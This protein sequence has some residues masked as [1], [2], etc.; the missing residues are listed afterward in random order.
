MKQN[1]SKKTIDSLKNNKKLRMFFLFLIMSF[2][3]WMLIKLSEEYIADVKIEV[4]YIDQPN[5]KLL[6]SEPQN[7]ITLTLKATGFNLL[8]HRIKEKK[9]NY[10]LKDVK[11]KKSSV[12]YS[13]TGSNINF[14]QAQFSAEY[15]L[16]NVKPDTLYFDF[17]KKFSKKV[18]VISDIN[19][20]FKSGFNLVNAT[21]FTPEFITISGP[22]GII[23]SIEEI[24]MET[25]II[26][27]IDKSFEKSIPLI[28]PDEK[29]SLSVDQV[30]FK[31]KVDKFTEGT[32]MIPFEV[33]NVPKT[34]IISAYP[35]EV[36]VV[37]KV[38]LS[39]YNNVVPESFKV[40]CDFRE[41]QNNN[42]EY[43]MPKIIKQ[44]EII[45]SVKIVPNKIEYLIKK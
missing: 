39:D 5:K 9:F 38:A 42:L 40:I 1:Q 43:L 2:L 6:Q 29:V 13:E 28:V 36:R 10:S 18:K 21:V 44:P 41:S 20:E 3:F 4:N 17:G 15:N 34:S 32:F 14:I 19:L 24:K 45:T 25:T 33:I 7:E 16:L 23:D 30:L 22:K 35:K 11:H 37:F 8:K 26:N 31:A 12:Y 27:K